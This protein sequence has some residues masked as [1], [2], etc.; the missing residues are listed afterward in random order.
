MSLLSLVQPALVKQSRISL[1][2]WALEEKRRPMR[3]HTRPSKVLFAN[4][5]IYVWFRLY[6]VR[7]AALLIFVISSTA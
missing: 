3:R 4:N 6:Q 1:E 5:A 7:V 2:N